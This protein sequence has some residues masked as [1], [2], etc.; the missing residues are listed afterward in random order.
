[1]FV[2]L[3]LFFK[4]N[5]L[6]YWRVAE[7][8]F[9][10]SLSNILI[11]FIFNPSNPVNWWSS[12]EFIVAVL[13]CIPITESNRFIGNKLETKF[14]WVLHAKKRFIYQLLYVSIVILFFLNVIAR[15]YLWIL[16]DTFFARYEIL[17][18][19]LIVFL[20]TLLLVI[21]K[22]AAH[23]LKRWK[24]SEAN[25][26]KTNLK[27]EELTSNIKRTNQ[28]IK[29]RNK[30]N[31]YIKGVKEI[32]VVKIEYG[33]V[34]V[35]IR[36]SDTYVFNGTLSQMASLLPKNIFF[37]VSRNLIV[38]KE[39]ITS[40]TP[41]SY[42]KILVKLKEINSEEKEITVSRLKASAFRKWYN[43]TSSLNL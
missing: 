16:D 42:G 37:Q 41:S 4:Y 19:N 8:L 5:K 26:K 14:N 24:N 36:T 11:N 10:G 9:L 32:R 21:F 1:M 43:S 2:K 31:D 17:I 35:F 18:I 30:N 3:K 25:L 7:P 39:Q 34:R 20:I 15:V 38:H 6:S 27:F 29:L 13:F 23:F 22:W 33:I 12:K 40:I 28:S